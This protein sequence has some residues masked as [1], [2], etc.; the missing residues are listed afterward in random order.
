[1]IHIG[2]SPDIHLGCPG[3]EDSEAE[4]VSDGAHIRGW[5]QEGLPA[6]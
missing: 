5:G 6:Q 2:K 3:Q 1:M 4:A